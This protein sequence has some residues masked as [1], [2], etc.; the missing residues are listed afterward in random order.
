MQRHTGHLPLASLL[1]A[2]RVPLSSSRKM[3][4]EAAYTRLAQHAEEKLTFGAI[5]AAYDPS[6]DSR[7]RGNRLAVE[8]AMAEYRSLWTTQVRLFPV[9]AM[10]YLSDYWRVQN[11]SA[12]VSKREF[13]DVYAD[14]SPA[15][16]ND[17]HF[18]QLLAESWK[19]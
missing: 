18:E 16:A 13:L 11:A 12:E 3:Q 10:P 15:V 19:N 7:V 6:I 14:I 4:I 9:I 8:D 1:G 2:L 17:A 5:C